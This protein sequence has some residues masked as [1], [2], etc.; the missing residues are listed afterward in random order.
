MH[1]CQQ[2]CGNRLE[3]MMRGIARLAK[4]LG[5]STGTVS[6]AL[7]G[8]PDVNDAT[9][10]RVLEAAS[11]IGY[12]PN[13]AARALAQGGTRSVG[14]MIDLDP[15]T[16][17]SSDYFFMGVF[18]GVQ[19]VLAEEG[20]D[21]LVLPCPTGQDHYTYLERFVSRGVVDAMI[22]AAVQREDPRIDLLKLAKI[23]FVTLGRSAQ[24]DDYSWIDLDFE[25]TAT[26]A[27]E[28]L[29]AFGHRRIAI[30]VPRGSVN[31][32]Y[33]FLNTCKAV[34]ARNGITLSPELVFET[35][36]TESAG[37]EA[38]QAMLDLSEPPTAVLLIYEVTAIG[39]YRCLFERG[40]APGRDLAV[41]GFRDEPTIRFL[42]PS[43]TCFGLSLRELGR[44]VGTAL[45][46]Q[47][48]RFQAKYPQGVMQSLH[49]LE[50]HPGESDQFTRIQAT[51]PVA[52][53]PAL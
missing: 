38:A 35:R 52:S 31:F 29:I 20:L 28:R 40:L 8:K 5:I 49:P 43:L 3:A 46:A 44:S 34:M 15:E 12:A 32:G 4:E 16:A 7:N 9:R 1:L 37:Y 23:P 24:S 2:G 33:V 18:D 48:P 39:V 53:D 47:I 10:A 19:S 50:M 42:V 41:V 45:L 36:R 51:G 17:A 26:V 13:H 6:R 14:F 30:T 25:G 22:L 21:L 27:L 11:R